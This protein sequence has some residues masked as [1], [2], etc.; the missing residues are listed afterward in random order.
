MN[1]STRQGRKMSIKMQR[2]VRSVIIPPASGSKM[3]STNSSNSSENSYKKPLPS[4]KE[5]MKL[6]LC[7]E[8]GERGHVARNCNMKCEEE[9]EDK[10]LKKPTSSSK[11]R[12]M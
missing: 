1:R 12:R 9:N 10:G 4:H 8:C 11:E 3:N 6:G 2:N 7:F 5:M